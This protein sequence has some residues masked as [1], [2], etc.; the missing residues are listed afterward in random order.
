MKDHHAKR[1]R[2]ARPR[3]S[4]LL[5][6]M[7]LFA[8]AAGSAL[9][10]PAAEAPLPMPPT[11][12]AS[13][14]EMQAMEDIEAAYQPSYLSLATGDALAAHAT[15]AWPFDV[16]FTLGHAIQSYQYYG[17]TAAYFHHGIDI[18]PPS[19]SRVYCRSG[20]QVVKVYQYDTS[21]SV[22]WEVAVL[23]PEGYLWQYHHIDNSTIPQAIW[24]AYTAYQAN[25][26]TGGFISANTYIGNIVWWSTVSFGYNF[27]HVHLNILA[28]GGQYLNGFEFMTPLAD[29]VA[30]TIRGIGLLKNNTP[31]SGNETYGDY[32]LYVRASDLVL[33][34]VYT[35]PPY[36]V[37]YSLDG[38]A[39][40]TVWEFANLPGGGDRY[41]FPKDYYVVP[42]TCGNYTCRDF[43]IDLGFTT[44]GQR[45]FPMTAGQHSVHVTVYD[46]AGN[47]AAGD[48]AWTVLTGTNVFFDDFE[49]AAPTHTWTRNPNS[50]DTATIGGRRPLGDSQSCGHHLHPGRHLQLRREA[51]RHDGQRRQGSGYRRFV[52]Q[53][54]P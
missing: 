30:P 17:S 22:Y 40:T 26:T 52:E 39:D 25:P 35:L 14:A 6:L 33:N 16:S 7:L 46:Y 42:P 44:A 19:R 36:K 1:T 9:A 5:A 54:R 45:A 2:F 20:G 21:S 38:G 37:V 13:L 29:T 34:T 15:Y 41:L 49:D 27:H 23:D 53:L 10:A 8:S 12:E 47:S 18:M 24:D 43:Y 32:G 31:I 51:A 50:T 4:L 48:F 11:P 3:L 28:S